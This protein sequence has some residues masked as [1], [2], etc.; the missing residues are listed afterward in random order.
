MN[1][2][3]CLI[4]PVFISYFNL[5]DLISDSLQVCLHVFAVVLNIIH[6]ISLQV[7]TRNT[8]GIQWMQVLQML[9]H[10][11]E[12]IIIIIFHR[13]IGEQTSNMG[14]YIKTFYGRN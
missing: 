4:K 14:L 11:T 7:N 2:K 13:K 6:S 10:L 12:W 1:I 5:L 9:D 3:R 8:V